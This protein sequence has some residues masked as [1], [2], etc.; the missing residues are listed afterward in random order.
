MDRLRRQF[1]AQKA[2]F[3]YV[4][5]ANAAV[6]FGLLNLAY[7]H[8]HVT[9]VSA[10]IVSTSCAMLFSFILNRHFVFDDTTKRLHHHALLFILVTVTGSLLVLN[11]VYIVTLHLLSGHATQLADLS[12]QLT[13][14]RIAPSLIEINLSTVVGAI[15][16]MFWNYNGYRRIVFNGK[17]ASEG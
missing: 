13:G 7:Y 3:V 1:G 8:L 5:L 4:G 10:S 2:R 11:G 9:K 17:P 6:S 15:A 14:I 12:Q 16:T